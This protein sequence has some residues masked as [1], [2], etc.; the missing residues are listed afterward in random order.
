MIVSFLR[1]LFG[2]TPPKV[3]NVVVALLGACLVVVVNALQ[4]FS[5]GD[6]IDVHVFMRALAGAVAAVL[7]DR[8]IRPL[9]P[10]G[11]STK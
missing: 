11:S 1:K 2:G 9:A 5:A 7:I 4:A 3:M 8:L 6:L 10:A